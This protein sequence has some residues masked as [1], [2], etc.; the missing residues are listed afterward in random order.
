MERFQSL[1]NILDSKKQ[2]LKIESYGVS[3]T[4]LEDVFLHIQ[5]N[6]H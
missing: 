3:I 2:E 4:S 1:F 5:K 6:E